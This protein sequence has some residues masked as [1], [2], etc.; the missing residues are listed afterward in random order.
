MEFLAGF[1]IIVESADLSYIS[2]IYLI[3]QLDI[4]IEIL[5]VAY[6][7]VCNLR[8]KNDYG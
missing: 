4:L 7:I 6:N 2:D 8:R 3:V 1:V 5:Y